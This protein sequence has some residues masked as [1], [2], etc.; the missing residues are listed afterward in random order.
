M[1]FLWILLRWICGFFRIH[2]LWSLSLK[3]NRTILSSRWLLSKTLRK[4]LRQVLPQ[5]TARAV[6]Q[7]VQGKIFLPPSQI[8]QEKSLQY[9]V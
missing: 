7:I 6:L 9:Q 1:I 2:P 4:E 3:P 8:F 5:L